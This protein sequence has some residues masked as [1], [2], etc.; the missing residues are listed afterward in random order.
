MSK[1]DLN[2]EATRLHFANLAKRYGN[3]IIIL[4]LIK[5]RFY[6]SKV[7]FAPQFPYF[8]IKETGIAQTLKEL[9]IKGWLN[10]LVGVVCSKT[11]L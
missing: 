5:V 11:F 1:K 4:N 2:Y 8:S 3:P 10:N 7:L 9:K 6:Y